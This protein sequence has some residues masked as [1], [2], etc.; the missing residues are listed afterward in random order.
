MKITKNNAVAFRKLRK[1]WHKV[2]KSEVVDIED[3]TA[4]ACIKCVL[5]AMV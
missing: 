5:K 4:I 3:L 1:I 2:K